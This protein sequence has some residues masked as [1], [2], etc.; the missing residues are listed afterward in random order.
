MGSRPLMIQETDS[1]TW[2]VRGNTPPFVSE[3][4][5]TH[6]IQAELMTTCV[7]IDEELGTLYMILVL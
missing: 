7:L 1:E 5:K 6:E 2:M 3:T 4:L